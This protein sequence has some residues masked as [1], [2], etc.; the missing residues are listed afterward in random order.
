MTLVHE[1][2][3]I[4][5][6]EEHVLGLY[7]TLR[8]LAWEN[9]VPLLSILANRKDTFDIF[10]VYEGEAA[11]N[12]VYLVSDGV[13]EGPKAYNASGMSTKALV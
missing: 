5:N 6:D 8:N 13:K 4:H 11:Q 9:P 2:W 3:Y 7:S 1:D 10:G 12:P